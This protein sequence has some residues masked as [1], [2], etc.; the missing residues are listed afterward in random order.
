VRVLL[1]DS[2]ESNAIH[3]CTIDDHGGEDQLNIIR[4]TIWCRSP[5]LVRWY[6]VPATQEW[7]RCSAI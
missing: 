5:Q 1:V 7:Y 2:V 4:Q 3:S 6:L